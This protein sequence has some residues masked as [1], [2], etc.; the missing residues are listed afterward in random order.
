[1]ILDGLQ[2]A[3]LYCVLKDDTFQV[4]LSFQTKERFEAKAIAIEITTA[5][6]SLE[7]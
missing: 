2:V 3:A 7:G 4:A 6:R 5:C 1:M